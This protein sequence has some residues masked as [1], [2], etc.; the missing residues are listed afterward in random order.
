MKKKIK[1]WSFRLVTTA[2]LMFVLLI[3]IVFTPNFL[4]ANKT[5]IDNYT[6][7]HNGKIN[8]KL[9][10]SL[11]NAT[12]LLKKSELYDAEFKLDICLNDGS[13]YPFL[14]EKIQ[15]QAFA[16]GFY[17]KIVIHGQV[18][19]EHNSVELNGYEWNLEELLAHEAIH[20]YQYNEFGFL[21]SKPITRYPNWKWEG[22]PEY[23]ARQANEYQD[24]SFNIQ[25]LLKYQ[26]TNPESWHIVFSD[27]KIV[28]IDYYKDWL[29]VKYCIEEKQLSYKELLKDTTTKEVIQQE[30]MNWFNQ[31][32]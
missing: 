8:T 32:Q 1:T 21:G 23:I 3:G 30:M 15:G 4:Y 12:A 31:K 22:Y 20:C 17:N 29:L 11:K 25:R 5:V 19:L 18:D 26:K 2:S 27:E 28:P 16:H 7:Y 10:Q 13:Y 14:I 24:L 6:V 9:A